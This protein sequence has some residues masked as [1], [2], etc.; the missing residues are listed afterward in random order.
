M[1]I[2]LMPMETATVTSISKALRLP[3]PFLNETNCAF[4]QLETWQQLAA[5]VATECVKIKP[6]GYY[7]TPD[8]I[9]I[10]VFECSMGD[11]SSARRY[12]WKVYRRYRHF[13]NYVAHSS[14]V[15]VSQS[16]GIPQLSHSYL[17]IFYAQDCKD[18]LV[19]LHTW[20]ERV[21]AVTQLYCKKLC[22]KRQKVE[23]D[24]FVKLQ[25]QRLAQLETPGKPVISRKQ[26][27]HSSNDV[28]VDMT[29][30][31]FESSR[32]GTSKPLS[33]GSQRRSTRLNL[34][35]I[36]QQQD[37]RLDVRRLENAEAL[38][39]LMLSCFLFAGANCP[40]PHVF[41][42][43]PRFA[44]AL[45]ELNVKID[46]NVYPSRLKNRTITKAGLGLRLM[47]SHEQDAKYFGA[48][49]AGLLRNQEEMDPALINVSV[50]AQLVQ[51][52]GIDTITMPFDQILVQLRHAGVPLRLKFL[53]N[54]HNNC[55]R[56]AGIALKSS[57]NTTTLP[58]TNQVPSGSTTTL[59]TKTP[60]THCSVSDDRQ[61]TSSLFS[62]MFGDWFGTRRVSQT[63]GTMG[64]DL[65][66]TLEKQRG[67]SAGITWEST[68]H[69]NATS[70]NSWDDI[71]GASRDLISHGFYSKLSS[72]LLFELNTANKSSIY[73][74]DHE[75]CGNNE[76]EDSRN[77]TFQGVWSTASTSMG[78]TF[79]ACTIYGVEAVMLASDPVFFAS[80]P[81][82]CDSEKRLCRGFVL[83]AINHKSTFGA[84][85]ATV[86][87][88]LCSACH[89]TTL[90]F[91][92]FDNYSPLLQK[93]VKPYDGKQSFRDI[94]F[95]NRLDC[96][97]E[98][99]IGLSNCLQRA[100]TE[101]AALRDEL[102][103]LQ[104]AHREVRLAHERAAQREYLLQVTIKQLNLK[105]AKLTEKVALER[106][107]LD[108]SKRRMQEAEAAMAVKTREHDAMM[109]RTRETAMTRLAA[110]QEQLVKE[111]KRSIEMATQLVEKRAQKRLETAVSACQRE[112]DEYL[113]KLAEEHSEEIQ[114]LAQQVAVW[115]RQVEILTEAEKRDYTAL[116]S[117]GSNP[118][119]DY[120]RSRFG[121][122]S[123]ELPFTDLKI[124]DQRK[125]EKTCDSSINVKKHKLTQWQRQ[126]V[127]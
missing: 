105:L 17:E 4:Q 38:P 68:W 104:D 85:I 125:Q 78:L 25:Q 65:N 99:Q 32:V 36:E 14:E 28:T 53:Y 63:Q 88:R 10:Y 16:V 23:L 118:Y 55:P 123:S 66:N 81:E 119:S 93:V 24:K 9:D 46:Q 73:F 97:V 79:S 71:N 18:R 80:R 33:K 21:V 6:L 43:I 120:Q 72:S 47:P 103:V 113:Q 64:T 114:S 108:Q 58:C 102:S 13:K 75:N 117:L 15:L 61:S 106:A 70:L 69:P 122:M 31:S 22:E 3:R 42:A 74:P 52:N 27:N 111:S 51:V 30:D 62:A 8:S 57:G 101:N 49:V 37:P 94:I 112:H 92:W 29:F 127:E 2:P 12:R 96:I 50:G 11:W 20:L 67:T 87:T 90:C 89:P 77:R 26:K 45:Q 59:V 44:L 121:Y 5:L 124:N 82:H 39:I 40:F 7:R 98:A 91:R 1:Q 48:T 60:L 115:R 76:H 126:L 19:E 54:R 100:L 56:S 34:R 109:V 35:T 110:Q 41:Q 84:S 107:N 83:V 86:F 95:N 116:M